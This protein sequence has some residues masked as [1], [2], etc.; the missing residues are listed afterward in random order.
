M[1]NVLYKFS[2]KFR[3]F[4]KGLLA[5]AKKFRYARY[6]IRYELE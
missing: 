2:N 6:Y 5:Y 3:L 4:K 1:I